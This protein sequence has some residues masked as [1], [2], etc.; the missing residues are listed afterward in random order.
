M[1]PW[2]T[3][4]TD[5]PQASETDAHVA[6]EASKRMNESWKPLR[7]PAVWQYSFVV[8]CAGHHAFFCYYL[9]RRARSS[10]PKIKVW[11]IGLFATGRPCS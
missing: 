9:I 4:L 2:K 8:L 10:A 11:L 6:A 1:L 3:A 7:P 5:G